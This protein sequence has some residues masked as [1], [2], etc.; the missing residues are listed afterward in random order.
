MKD[1]LHLGLGG[2]T[3]VLGRWEV[4]VK[5]FKHIGKTKDRD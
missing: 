1:I 3:D 2:K 4:K 5:V